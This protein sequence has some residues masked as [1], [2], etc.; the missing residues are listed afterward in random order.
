ME[1]LDQKAVDKRDTSYKIQKGN[2]P[3]GNYLSAI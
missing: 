1:F 2:C 3:E